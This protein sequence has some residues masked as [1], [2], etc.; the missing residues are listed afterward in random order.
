MITTIIKYAS[1]LLALVSTSLAAQS[2][3]FEFEP[4]NEYTNQLLSTLTEQDVFKGLTKFASDNF[5]LNED[6]L[7]SFY[8]GDSVFFDATGNKVFIPYSFLI[9]LNEG[10]ISRYPQQSIIRD[11]IFAAAIEQL[12]WFEF[13]RALVSQ[14]ALPISGQEE[15]ALD[16]FAVMM[17][18]QFNPRAQDYLLD[19]AEAY[20]LVDDAKSL[21]DSSAQ[22]QPISLDEQR[23]RRIVCIIL[24]RDYEPHGELIE[25]I[26]WNETRLKQCEERFNLRLQVWYETL[27][28]SLNSESPLHR[29]IQEI[30]PD[31]SEVNQD[32]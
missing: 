4:T 14:F 21:L 16:E 22:Q 20:L 32:S 23:Y 29:L 24:G 19:S 28:P 1:L 3:K 10:L 8:Q 27:R 12:L 13:G 30:S 7:F 6:V 18:L 25:E 5:Q 9:E 15:V 11:D 31:S 2:V 26:A 17:L